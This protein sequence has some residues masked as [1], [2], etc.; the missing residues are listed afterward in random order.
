[1][2]LA[3]QPQEAALNPHT[4]LDHDDMHHLVNG[5][6]LEVTRQADRIRRRSHGQDWPGAASA[7]SELE[8]AVEIL[9]RLV[10]T[11]LHQAI[12]AGRAEQQQY[13]TDEDGPPA[14][15]PTGQYL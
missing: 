9:G 2:S 8:E 4:V 15:L 13:E 10:N 12:A 11:T 3:A 14:E 5:L 1:M 7:M 6:S